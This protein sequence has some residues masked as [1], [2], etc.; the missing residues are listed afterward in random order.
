MDTIHKRHLAALEIRK[1]L[2]SKE[3]YAVIE[4]ML[5]S[6]SVVTFVL[7]PGRNTTLE[8]L[9]SIKGRIERALKLKGNYGIRFRQDS[10]RILMEVPK[11]GEYRFTVDPIP[12]FD[13]DTLAHQG[14]AL[15][16]AL[17]LDTMGVKVFSDLAT[18]PHLLI[19]GTTGSG[20][21]IA[22]LSVVT[23][24]VRHCSPDSLQLVLI[25]PKRVELNRFNRLA[26]L[27]SFNG[28]AGVITDMEQAHEVIKALKGE[29]E[30]RYTL[31]EDSNVES[32]STYSKEV[33]PLPYIVCVI[34]EFQGYL[35]NAPKDVITERQ[36]LVSIIAAQGRAAGIHLIMATQKPDANLMGNITANVD[37]RMCL[38]VTS[39]TD[40]KII[41][42]MTGGEGLMGN[43]DMLFRDKI[44]L[45]RIQTPFVQDEV[46]R[47]L[48][49]EERQA[50]RKSEYSLVDPEACDLP[51][52]DIKALRRK[53]KLDQKTFANLIGVP[54][55]LVSQWEKGAPIPQGAVRS[56]IL[57]MEKE[58]EAVQRAIS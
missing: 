9:E 56:F 34:D 52:I 19:G 57:V 13:K 1:V 54:A 20:K 48:L 51:P 3:Q 47:P 40:S 22:L 33:S 50:T 41:L 36:S 24:L 27:L 23:S 4:N 35:S 32:I 8:G 25:D 2:D 11:D 38:R 58:P 5:S 44:G 26:H 42:G 37:G 7:R 15:P 28:R 6:A 43:G 49:D 21:S 46:L 14:M 39:H 30:R 45:T 55:K 10:G 31:F 12:F 29:M 16:L 53:L 18:L 17:G